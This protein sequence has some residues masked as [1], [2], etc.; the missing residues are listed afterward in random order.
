MILFVKNVQDPRID[1]FERF[2]HSF[3]HKVHCV[4][5]LEDTTQQELYNKLKRLLLIEDSFDLPQVRLFKTSLTLTNLKKYKLEEEID[6]FLYQSMFYK[7]MQ[8]QLQTYILSETF[9]D[10]FYGSVKALTGISYNENVF[11]DH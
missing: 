9:K 11:V 3:N 4:L 1:D 10:K 8:N 6:Y 5:A 7:Y 2:A